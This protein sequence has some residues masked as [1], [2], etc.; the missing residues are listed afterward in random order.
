MALAAFRRIVI[1][2]ASLVVATGGAATPETSGP[3]LTVEFRT[4]LQKA[5]AAFNERNFPAALAQCEALDKL[6]PQTAVVLNMRGAIA[7]EE[8]RFADGEKFCRK[9]VEID[10]KFFPARFNLA[11]IPFL[12]K[13]F[14]AA[15]TIYEELLAEDPKNELL[16]YRIF[17]TYLLEGNEAGAEEALKKV[18][19]PGDTAA[20]YYAHAAW[21]FQHGH[22]AEGEKWINSGDWVFSKAKN[23]YFVDVFYDLGWLKRPNA[24][25]SAEW[26]A[27]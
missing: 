4:S 14:V 10:P 19:F 22:Q 12:Q 20:Y 16:Q 27:G 25:P 24:A 3:N 26:K 18:H 6:Q 13:Q 23:I 11:E 15:R 5:I 2:W 9:A 1:L 17:L 8:R 21:E 7:L